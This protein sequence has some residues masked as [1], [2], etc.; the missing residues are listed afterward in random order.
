MVQESFSV[1]KPAIIAAISFIFLTDQ[2]KIHY[3]HPANGEDNTPNMGI[4]NTILG[5]KSPSPD[6]KKA[7]AVC[8]RLF[9]AE[10][11]SDADIDSLIA[12]GDS[13]L[14]AFRSELQH[15]GATP[16]INRSERI[17]DRLGS[18]KRSHH[19]AATDTNRIALLACFLDEPKGMLAAKS[20]TYLANFGGAAN[21]LLLHALQSHNHRTRSYAARALAT[22]HDKRASALLI[23]ALNDDDARV[24]SDA[25]ESLGKLADTQAIKALIN[26][27]ADDNWLVR[28]SAS[29]ALACFDHQ[30]MIAKLTLLMRDHSYRM[31][32]HTL[33]TISRIGNKATLP[34]L[35]AGLDDPHQEVQ[36]EA[37]TALASYREAIVPLLAHYHQ[38]DSALAGHIRSVCEQ[39][40]LNRIANQLSHRDAN[41]R[42]CAAK[43]LAELDCIEL[44]PLL[45][46][47]WQHERNPE[48]QT[49]LIISIAQ[50]I[51]R[52]GKNTPDIA[53]TTLI[54][55]MDS[56]NKNMAYHAQ[57]ALDSSPHPLAKQFMQP[58][59][60]NSKIAINCPSCLQAL[61]LE[62]PLTDKQWSCPQCHL[63]FRIQHGN[64]D[65]LIVTPLTSTIQGS[66]LAAHTLPWFEILQVAADAD[67]S[68]IKSSFRT[69]LKQYHPDKVTRLGTE[70]KQLAEEK[71]HLLTWA[72]RA[73]LKQNGQ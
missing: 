33:R 20:I 12:L 11:L 6:A 49:N 45:A 62:P 34:L 65:A 23:A 70:F 64:S 13:G 16:D 3:H 47:A 39:H 41:I 73:G 55:A 36:W 9:R 66:S 21:D 5:R 14:Q 29:A 59:I 40:G 27:L 50:Q 43:I 25:A 19:N 52:G 71:T 30:S 4:F 44:I 58:A 42:I 68:T 22:C 24:R 8:H 60:Q 56:P 28:E 54:Q 63:G 48:V 67:V 31:R 69:L 17:I 32:L 46:D 72:L 2:I 35:L 51:A 57:K 1:K 15:D 61:Q 26:S 53:I 18:I 38:A 37:V 7:S 10:Q